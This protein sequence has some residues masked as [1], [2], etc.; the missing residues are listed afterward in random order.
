MRTAFIAIILLA[1]G[2]LAF[3]PSAS[4]CHA[5][6]NGIYFGHNIDPF[7]EREYYWS[8]DCDYA[9]SPVDC[10]IT[11]I[12]EYGDPT[13]IYGLREGLY[14][15]ECQTASGNGRSETSISVRQDFDE[16][17]CVPIPYMAVVGQQV[18][19]SGESHCTPRSVEEN[20]E[21]EANTPAFIP[22]TYGYMLIFRDP[23]GGHYNYWDLN[24][25]EIASACLFSSPDTTHP[26][27]WGIL[28]A[29]P[30]EVR[31]VNCPH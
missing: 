8:E 24:T 30:A 9:S 19:G 16:S 2:L 5:T 20:R 10:T 7:N 28:Q 21:A 25:A 15:Y 11:P 14:V 18:P 3:S 26:V 13:P 31:Y 29:G 12:F 22:T 6:G 23:V 4:A 27:R 1:G 17:R